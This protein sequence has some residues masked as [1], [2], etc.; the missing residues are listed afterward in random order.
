[1]SLYIISNENRYYLD[2]IINTFYFDRIADIRGAIEKVVQS[3]KGNKSKNDIFILK[4]EIE[5]FL[6]N[7][8]FGHSMDHVFII[9]KKGIDLKNAG[10]LAAFEKINSN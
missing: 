3:E 4:L 1:M 6:E 8:D 5:R 2:A 9:D 10:S 7:N